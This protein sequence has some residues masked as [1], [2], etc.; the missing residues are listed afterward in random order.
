VVEDLA[1]LGLVYAQK[2]RTLSMMP[3]YSTTQVSSLYCSRTNPPSVVEDLTVLGLVSMQKVRVL[4][5]ITLS[6]LLFTPVLTLAHSFSPVFSL[7]SPLFSPLL[8]NLH[9]SLPPSPL[10]LWRCARL[11]GPLLCAHPAWQ[12]ASLPACHKAR[13]A[14]SSKVRFSEPAAWH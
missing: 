7:P 6:S 13:G 4:A 1:V 11:Q 3:R 8:F 5:G 14:G 10:S 9:L 2:V 12:Q